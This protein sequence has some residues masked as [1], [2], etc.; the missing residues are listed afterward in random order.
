M[1]MS[2]TPDATTPV[3]IGTR[4]RAARDGGIKIVPRVVTAGGS[5]KDW[6]AEARRGDPLDEMLSKGLLDGSQGSKHDRKAVARS[7]YDAGM[8]L[9]KLFVDAGLVGAHAQD[10]QPRNFGPAEMSDRQAEAVRKF[11]QMLRGVGN[12]WAAIATGPA[13]HGVYAPTNRAWV[14]NV[15]VSLDKLCE[16]QER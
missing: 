4:E 8:R 6:G 7:R 5:V 3:D 1:H 15:C 12:S 13:C 14:S 16:F 11:S 10:F 2:K 9:A